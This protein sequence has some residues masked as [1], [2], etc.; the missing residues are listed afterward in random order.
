MKNS[1]F[2]QEH[3]KALTSQ[4]RLGLLHLS[5]VSVRMKKTR[6]NDLGETSRR[7]KHFEKPEQSDSFSCGEL[8]GK[9][10]WKGLLDPL[11]ID[12]RRSIISY[13]EL[14]QA[15]YDGFNQ[16]RRSPH[17]GA[18]LYGHSDLLAGSG[19]SAAADYAVT[20]FVYA[21]SA[22]PV[23][24]AFLRLPPPALKDAWCRESNWIGY[25]AAATDEGAARLGRRDIVVA[26]RGTLR[27]LEWVDDFDFTPVPAAPVLGSAAAAHPLAVAHRG[28]LSVY[29]SSNASSKFNRS[30]A[31]DQESRYYRT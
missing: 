2:V 17:A 15:T 19:A 8:H 18:C 24:D 23:P 25:V 27:N 28:F 6:E 13:G 1:K 30:S 26:W 9:D 22:L 31:R 11:D 16:E 12:L 14:A 7:L 3:R 20:K 29:R 4:V 10:S 5:E 21:T